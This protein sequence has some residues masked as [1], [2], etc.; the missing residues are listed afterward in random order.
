V[1]GTVSN[2]TGIASQVFDRKMI[3]ADLKDLVSR[4]LKGERSDLDVKF[5]PYLKVTQNEFCE[6]LDDFDYGGY[7]PTNTLINGN[8]I[9]EGT[10][11][12]VDDDKVASNRHILTS[13][14]IHIFFHKEKKEN[15][16]TLYAIHRIEGFTWGAGIKIEHYE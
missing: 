4:F 7:E 5:N 14:I 16:T 3:L 10:Y 8:L 11:M 6:L 13:K 12:Y 9:Y 2:G 15:G 1:S